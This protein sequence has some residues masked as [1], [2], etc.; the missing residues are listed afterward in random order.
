M[1]RVAICEDEQQQRELVR[2]ML[3]ALS[4]KSNIE[5]EIE[6]FSS[7]EQLL[8]HYEREETPFHILILDVEMNGLNGIQTARKIRGLNRLDEQIVFLTSYPEYM[9]ESFDVMTFQYLLKPVAPSI[10]EEKIMKLCQYFQALHKKFLVIKSAYEEVVLKYD[11][12]IGIEAAKSLTIKSKLNFI[13][14]HGT[15]ESKGILADYAAALK[16]SNFLQIHRSIIINLLHVKKFASGVVLMSSGL[17]LPIGR[18]K[19]KEVKDFYTK[20]MIMRVNEYD[21]R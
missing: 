9:V 6:L 10:L 4:I 1:Y 15:Y 13:T 11:D 5:F 12:I 21:S 17:E 2:S 14:S 20:F 7:G 3:I 16:D 19:I 8:S 18:S